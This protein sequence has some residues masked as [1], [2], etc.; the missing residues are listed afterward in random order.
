MD[1]WIET[2]AVAS[3]LVAGFLAWIYSA[4][5]CLDSYRPNPESN[6]RKSKT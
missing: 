4:W 6:S 1:Q 3:V 2:L 5:I